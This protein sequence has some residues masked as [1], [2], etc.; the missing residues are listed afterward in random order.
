MFIYSVAFFLLGFLSTLQVFKYQFF[1]ANFYPFDIIYYSLI[2]FLIINLVISKEEKKITLS[3]DSKILIT[4][5]LV[6]YLFSINFFTPILDGANKLYFLVALKYLIKKSIFVAFFFFVLFSSKE[7]KNKFINYFIFGFF[8]SIILHSI[9]SY[10]VLYFWYFQEIDIHTILLKQ[11]NITE[12]SVGHGFRNFIYFP[13]LRTIGFHWDPAY[14]GVWGIIVAFY[15]LIKS[16]KIWIKIS[17]L[18]IILIPWIF[19]FSR[20]AVF[21]LLGTT[22]ILIFYFIKF[23]THSNSLI[24]VNNLLV[25]FWL[26]LFIIP[27]IMLISISGKADFVKIFSSRIEVSDDIHTQKHLQYPIMALRALSDSP[28]HFV[29]GYGNRNSGRAVAHEIEII[30]EDFNSDRAFEV[31]SDLVRTPL[32]TG[33]LGFSSYLVFIVILVITLMQRYTKTN[34]SLYLFLSITVLLVFFSGFFYAY[35]DSVWV[36]M[37]WIIAIFLLNEED[38]KSLII[39]TK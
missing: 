32:N 9:Y 4:I 31:E 21:G 3:F 28:I 16:Y 12:A 25:G 11:I 39:T 35:N 37:F 34:E 10:I 6:Y 20:S 1:G 5:F 27:L 8:I 18:S 17:L 19:T 26:T 14:L 15:I 29:F 22:I 2:F 33:I 13:I 38:T 24:N 30:Q 23:K 7:I 36:W